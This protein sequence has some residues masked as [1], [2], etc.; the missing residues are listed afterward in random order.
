[1]LPDHGVHNSQVIDLAER[2]PDGTM[3]LVMQE[4]RQW[5]GSDQRLAEL[6]DKV[7][8]YLCFALD[9]Q[10]EREYPGASAQGLVLELEC[11]DAPDEL[12]RALLR[13][14]REALRP[15]GVTFD[16]RLRGASEP[17]HDPDDSPPLTE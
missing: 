10:M 6:Q 16:V 14:L 8:A 15:L 7:N 1:M 17:W 11:L 12:V 5:D 4:H 13:P 9:G 2:R 3:R